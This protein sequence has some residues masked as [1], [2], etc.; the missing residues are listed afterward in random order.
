A[1][2]RMQPKPE[3]AVWAVAFDP[4]SGEAVAGVR[5]THPSFGLVTGMVETD[6]K[7][8]MGC[9]GAPAVAYAEL[10]SIGA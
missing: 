5:T 1:R 8:W 4:D 10:S 7:L 9:I 6:G 2:G 3:S